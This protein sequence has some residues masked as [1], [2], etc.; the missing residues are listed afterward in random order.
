[1]VSLRPVTALCSLLIL[2]TGSLTISIVGSKIMANNATEAFGDDPPANPVNSGNAI[3]DDTTNKKGNSAQPPEK[4]GTEP[5]DRKVMTHEE[6]IRQQIKKDPIAPNPLGALKRGSFNSLNRFESF[7]LMNKGTER[8]F[9]GEYW[10]HKG[11][12][13]FVCRRCNAALYVSADKFDSGCGWPSFDDEVP[14]AV[15]RV[16]DQDGVRIEIVCTNC[17]GHLGHV[18]LGERFT[19]KNT[20]HCVNS[21]SIKFIPLDQPLPEII[22]PQD[23]KRKV[24]GPENDSTIKELPEGAE[25][26]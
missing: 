23:H 4:P 5:K 19:Q 2:L 10:N 15:T 21:A 12:G 22:R 13:T 7:V 18:F 16:P 11:D 20:R 6:A 14:G 1:M 3:N 17:G 9:T 8:A 26:R 24:A 25:G